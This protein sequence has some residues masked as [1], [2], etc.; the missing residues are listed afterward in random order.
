[1]KVDAL[2]IQ[3]D[4]F[5]S[6]I[7]GKGRSVTLF[8]TELNGLA[9]SLAPMKAEDVEAKQAVQS[10]EQSAKEP[11]D[12]AAIQKTLNSPFL[13]KKQPLILPLDFNIEQLNLANINITQ[14]AINP[15]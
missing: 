11:I 14:K 13:T 7:Q 4:H 2:D 8:P 10:K 3:L 12:W 5:Q 15:R 9:I 6:G 1:M